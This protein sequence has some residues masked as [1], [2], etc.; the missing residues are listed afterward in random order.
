MDGNGCG[1]KRS[2]FNAAPLSPDSQ[3]ECA[4]DEAFGLRQ[5]S[6]AFLSPALTTPRRFEIARDLHPPRAGASAC[7]A[8]AHEV[9]ACAK[10]T[11]GWHNRLYNGTGLATRLQASG[12][13]SASTNPH[14]LEA[15]LR[16]GDSLYEDWNSGR[17]KEKG[18]Q[19]P[20]AV[21]VLARS[22]SDCAADSFQ[23]RQDPHR[24]D[25][26]RKLR[27]GNR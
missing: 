15:Q 18:R 8:K 9:L 16:I 7:T 6:G 22:L 14:R 23:R 17:R 10:G 20:E 19:A 3:R 12:L 2:P 21:T 24:R 26:Y 11:G 25:R 27:R 5:S 1:L 13:Q 4:W